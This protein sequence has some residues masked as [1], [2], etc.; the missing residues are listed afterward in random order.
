MADFLGIPRRRLPIAIAMVLL[1]AATLVW[2]QGRFDQSDVRKGIAL[3]LAH[4]PAGRDGKSVFD[5]LVGVGRGDPRC[6]G[7][8]VRG[9]LAGRAPARGRTGMFAALVAAAA[10]AG[11]P[12]A[13]KVW[14][15][16]PASAAR[17]TA[18]PQSIAHLVKQAMPAVVGIVAV[19]ARGEPQDPFHDFLERM[20]GSGG[21]REQPVRGIGTGFFVRSD[22]LVA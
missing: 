8:V 4:R 19:T 20:Y 3:A 21:E 18:P 13:Q 9:L 2:L 22:G 11:A 14:T 12:Q 7:K 15:E 1:L 17:P 5:A 10:A 6:D 16:A